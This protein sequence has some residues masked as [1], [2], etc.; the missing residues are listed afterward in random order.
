MRVFAALFLSL[1]AVV[2]GYVKH[3]P[4]QS[5]CPILFSFSPIR[6]INRQTVTNKVFF[7]VEIEGGDKG[8]IVLGLFGETVPKTVENFRALC[9]GE[10]GQGK[11]G[12]PLHYKGSTFHRISKF[13]L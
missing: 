1:F 8:R 3:G 6:N 7:D 2:S 10:K 5:Q 4:L 9:T 11:Q 13:R 12:K